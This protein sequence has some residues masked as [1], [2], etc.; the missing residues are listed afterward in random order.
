MP[1]PVSIGGFPPDAITYVQDFAGTTAVVYAGQARSIQPKF[2]YTVTSV[3]KAAAAVVTI[4]AHGLQSD[5]PVVIEG[6][7]GAWAALN[8]VQKVT[9]LSDDTFSV[10]VNSGGFAGTFAGTISTTAPR[11]NASC[12]QVTKSYADATGL[13][14]TANASGNVA[15]DK[16]WT[17][18]ASLT[19]A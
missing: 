8:G 11:T 13:I 19:Y 4:T 18:R 6:G 3:S 9:V 14:R 10:P 7:A 12:W 16:A 15:A 2:A 17:S 5:N 1:A